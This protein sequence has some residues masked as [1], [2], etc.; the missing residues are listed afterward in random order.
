LGS[1][2]VI[3]YNL[4]QKD[5]AY[6]Y[7]LL[8]MQHLTTPLAENYEILANIYFDRKDHTIAFNYYC[9]SLDIIKS[10]LPLNQ[11]ALARV[12]K[13]LYRIEEVEF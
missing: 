6:D 2:S 12:E 13:L 1:L 9:K 5:L 7:S 11:V 3:Y 10:K 4:N 8:P